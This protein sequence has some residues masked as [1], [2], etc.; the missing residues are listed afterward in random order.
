MMTSAGSQ[1][2]LAALLGITHQ[3]LGRWLRADYIDDQGRTIIERDANGRRAGVVAIPPD[4]LPLINDAFKYHKQV[5]REQARI[6]RVPYNPNYPV[7][8][9][10]PIARLDNRPSLRFIANQT[11]FFRPRLRRD[12]ITT[13]ALTDKVIAF[14]VRSNINLYNYTK[15]KSA[16]PASLDNAFSRQA[17][18]DQKNRPT[19]RANYL[20]RL[21]AG[22][23]NPEFAP[24]STPLQQL[25][26]RYKIKQSIDTTEQKLQERHSP[27]ALANGFANQ[28]V[29]QLKETQSNAKPTARKRKP[30]AKRKK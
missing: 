10:R 17:M 1:R 14:T 3:K 4:A 11:H 29:F 30:A 13:V 6:D 22:V 28:I 15:S 18:T 26:K 5:T 8:Y 7:F 19:L 16:T 21:D 12:V 25:D 24:I 20:A 9:E 27:N 23:A 2:N